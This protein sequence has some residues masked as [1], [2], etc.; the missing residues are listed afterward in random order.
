[1]NLRPSTLFLVIGVVSV[2]HV[3]S[4]TAASPVNSQTVEDSWPLGLGTLSSVPARYPVQEGS[5]GAARLKVLSAEIGID[6]DVLPRGPASPLNRKI[7]SYVDEQIMRGDDHGEAPPQEI[8]EFFR[9]HGRPLDAI[10]DLLVTSPIAWPVRIDRTTH[11]PL[12][13]LRAH[14]ALTRLL[15]A[16][17]LSGSEWED[18]RAAWALQAGL[19]SRPELISQLVSLSSLKIIIAAA[20]KVSPPSPAWFQDV[21]Q[22]DQRRAILAAMQQQAWYVEQV[23]ESEGDDTTSVR[24]RLQEI[25]MKPFDQI[26]AGNTVALLRGVAVDLAGSREC[27]FDGIAFDRRFRSQMPFW[28]IVARNSTPNLGAVWQRVARFTAEREATA[29]VLAL[30]EGRTPR[31]SSNCSDGSWRLTQ[32]SSGAKHLR[33]SREISLQRPQTAIP[34]EYTVSK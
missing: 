1:M 12:P 18:L 25:V 15:V 24:D 29:I 8:V 17:A 3:A 11:A 27:A 14:L 21:M 10:R 13:N 6:F 7:A 34:L 26:F 22:I 31:L 4:A 19:R 5:V 30:K 28:N 9:S 32:D 16:R 33:F 20:R 23:V 2:L